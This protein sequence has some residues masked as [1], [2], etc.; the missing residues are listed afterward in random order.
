MGDNGGRTYDLEP[1]TLAFARDV[2]KL[3][4]NSR[5]S[6]SNI[7]IIRQLVRA[8]ASVGANYIEANESLG[9]R[10]FL[11]Y[12]RICRKEAKEARYWLQ[13]LSAEKNNRSQVDDLI[14]ES[15]ELMNIFG[16]IVRKCEAKLAS[17]FRSAGD[18]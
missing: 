12:A 3:A 5:R 1:R 4:E 14:R 8:S 10:D 9:R 2:L 17:S 18:S 7:E 11:M 15:T 16:A 6:T 13:L